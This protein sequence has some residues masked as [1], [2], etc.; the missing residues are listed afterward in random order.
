M[1]NWNAAIHPTPVF[2]GLGSAETSHMSSLMGSDTVSFDATSPNSS[3]IPLL[4]GIN[5][6]QASVAFFS[7]KAGGERFVCKELLE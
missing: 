1:K 3:A 6:P 7:P 2:T 5:R 4:Q